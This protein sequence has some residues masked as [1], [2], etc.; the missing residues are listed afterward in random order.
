MLGFLGMLWLGGSNPVSAQLRDHGPTQAGLHFD[1]SLGQAGPGDWFKKRRK[2]RRRRRKRTLAVGAVVGGP[3]GLGG[4]AVFRLGQIGVSGDLAYNRIRTDNGPLVD[5][6]TSKVDARFYSKGFFGKLLRFYVFAGTT[7]Q[8]GRWDGTNMRSAFFLDGGLGG[9]IK[10]WR[11]S[12]NAEAG[13][14]IP[15]RGV[16]NYQPRFGAFANLAVLIWLF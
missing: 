14:L 15:A 4:R 10:L 12:F 2:K 5:A 3:V 13:L 1:A 6:F 16:T 7:M 8:R 11:L 9:G